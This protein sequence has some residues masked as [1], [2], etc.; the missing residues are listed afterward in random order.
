MRMLRKHRTIQIYLVKLQTQR[1]LEILQELVENIRKRLENIL[2]II[3]YI[4]IYFIILPMK[5]PESAGRHLNKYKLFVTKF[6]MS[7]IYQVL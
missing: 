5:N 4:N 3:K 2:S 6:S 7:E 1:G